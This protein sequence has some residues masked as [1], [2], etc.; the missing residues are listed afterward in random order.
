MLF[1]SGSR[2]GLIMFVLAIMILNLKGGWKRILGGVLIG[3]MLAVVL[4]ILVMNV[5]FLYDIIGI[6]I[7][8]LLNLLIEGSTDEGSLNS[9]QELIEIGMEYIKKKPWTGYGYDCFKVVSGRGEGGYVSA[10]KFG[11]YS[12]NNYIELLF[13]GGII[14]LILYYIPML[15]LLKN[16]LQMLKKNPVVIYLLAIIVVKLVV[17]YAYVSCFER[18]DAYI[19]GIVLGCIIAVANTV[20]KEKADG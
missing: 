19:H 17:E 18:I 9:R 15:S 13:G 7:E 14:G 3:V 20:N 10:E 2:K 5:K 1:R 12:H 6:R 16:L 8:S 4:Y 11:Y